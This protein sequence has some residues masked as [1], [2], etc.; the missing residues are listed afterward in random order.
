VRTF[1][2]RPTIRPTGRTLL[3]AVLGTASAALPVLVNAALW[4]F[5]PIFWGL[6]AL[7]IGADYLLSP[8]RKLVECEVELPGSLYIGEDHLAL[9]RIRIPVDREV[10]FE[11]LADLSAIFEAQPMIRASA[12]REGSRVTIPLIPLRRGTGKLERIWLRYQGPLGL[13][14]LVTG[15]EVNRKLPVLPNIQP[16]KT[17]AL[18]FF[19]DRQFRAGLKVERYIGDGTEFDSMREYTPGLDHRALDWKHTA[20]HRKLI[21]RQNRAERNHQVVFSIDTGHLMCERL[22]GIPKLDHALNAALLL[23][24]ICLRTGDRVGLH[25]FDAKVGL[26][27]APQG[28]MKAHRR[29]TQ[30]SAEVNYS[31]SETNFTLG[32]TTLAQSMQRR[33]L[34]VVLTDFVDTVSAELMV[35]NLDRLSRKHLLLFVALQDPALRALARQTP[36]DNLTI[37][38]SVVAS[39]LLRDREL[40]MHRLRRRGILCID[41]PP[42]Q[43]GSALINTY[44]DVKRKERI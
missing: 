18:R 42:E 17:A 29:L 35:E 41:A 28:G 3:L 13:V 10:A 22:G 23:A 31:E 19:S 44:L 43:I 20:R 8:R 25:T 26:W 4:T 39:N 11:L 38:Q 15:F 5:W 16:V 9:L 1:H 2:P 36:R 6:L 27:A 7:A 21:C 30:L 14:G 40:V 24:Y 32:L 34:I 37:S 33:C 12:S